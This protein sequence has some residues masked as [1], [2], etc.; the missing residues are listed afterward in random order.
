MRVVNPRDF[1]E[2]KSPRKKSHKKFFATLSV[3]AVAVTYV[4]YSVLSPLPSVT[5][6]GITLSPLP[7]TDVAINWPTY[8]QAAVGAVGYGVLGTHGEQTP[9]PTASV[10]KVMTALAVLKKRPLAPGEQGP[11]ITYDQDDV[12]ELARVL[13]L[14]GSH[15]L[16]ALGE[17]ITQYQAI[18]ALLLP[19]SNNMAYT[20]SKWAFGSEEE[21]VVFANN[22]AKSLGMEHTTIS[23]AS[24]FSP[25]T[26]STAEDLTK[27]AVNAMDNPVIAEIVKQPDAIIPVAGRIYNVNDLLGKNGIIGLKT[28]NTDEAGGCFMAAAERVINGT[29]VVVVSVIMGAP[30]RSIALS[31]SVPLTDSVLDGFESTTLIAKGDL[32]GTVNVPWSGAVNVYAQEAVQ[33]IRWRGDELT[34]SVSLEVDGTRIDKGQ[35]IGTATA[36]FGRTI[37]TTNLVVESAVSP[38]SLSWKLKPKLAI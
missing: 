12:D 9:L 11:T 36:E 31:N 27:L 1:K 5:G 21:Y 13:E 35:S 38:P 29:R 32:V 4:V 25:E 15:N 30:T 3:F 34:V 24:G 10:A 22:F 20:I 37:S 26:V 23:D 17:D 16:V 7:R 8:G 19:S 14:G 33:G 2:L 6:S 18:Q 28:G